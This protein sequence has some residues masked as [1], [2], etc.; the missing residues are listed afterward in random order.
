MGVKQTGKLT[1]ADLE[2]LIKML[3]PATTTVTSGE[4]SPAGTVASTQTKPTASTLP[5]QQKK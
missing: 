3:R 1:H 2:N 5:Q 4:I